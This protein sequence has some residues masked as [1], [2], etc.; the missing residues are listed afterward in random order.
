VP[1][2]SSGSASSVTCQDPGRKVG[3][4]LDTPLIDEVNGKGFLKKRFP[5][6]Y[7]HF[8]RVKIDISKR[9]LLTYPTLH[10]QNG[11]ILIDEKG[12]RRFGTCSRQGKPRGNPWMQ[13]SMGNSLLDIFVLQKVGV[14]GG[15]AEVQRTGECDPEP[16][17]SLLRPAEVAPDLQC[18]HVANTVSP[19]YRQQAVA[20]SGMV[21]GVT[22]WIS[23]PAPSCPAPTTGELFPC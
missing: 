18:C 12:R 11:G 8:M 2:L 1:P 19:V 15:K 14:G 20:V 3:I 4:W 6:M 21:T 16:C 17:V 13:R 23:R 9:P 7:R 5:S 22:G 10:Y